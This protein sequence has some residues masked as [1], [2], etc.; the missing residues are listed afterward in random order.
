MIGVL[1]ANPVDV[2]KGETN[3]I[4]VPATVETLVEATVSIPETAMRDP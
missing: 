3:N 4:Q 1:I 2:V